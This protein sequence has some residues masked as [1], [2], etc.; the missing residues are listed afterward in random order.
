MQKPEIIAAGDLSSK[1]RVYE[2]KVQKDVI[3]GHTEVWAR[4]FTQDTFANIDE[5]NSYEIMVAAQ[6]SQQVSHTITMRYKDG[7]RADMAIY[8]PLENRVFSITGVQR[9]DRKRRVLVLRTL[10]RRDLDTKGW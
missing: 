10:E 5:T 7:V 4:V 6:N 1:V 3:G 9:K 8:W 2:K